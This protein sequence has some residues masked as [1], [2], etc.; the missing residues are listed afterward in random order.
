MSCRLLFS[1][2]CPCVFSIA[3]QKYQPERGLGGTR[4]PVDE[5]ASTED[6]VGVFSSF[7]RVI[8]GDPTARENLYI[9]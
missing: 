2:W 1:K 3:V 6:A 8:A 5:V 7:C 9:S 4:M